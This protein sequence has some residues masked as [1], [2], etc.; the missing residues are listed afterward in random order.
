MRSQDQI[1]KRKKISL[2]PTPG[3]INKILNGKLLVTI[4]PPSNIIYFNGF[5]N[6]QYIKNSQ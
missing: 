2:R 3:N 6:L 4:L 1:K 5:P